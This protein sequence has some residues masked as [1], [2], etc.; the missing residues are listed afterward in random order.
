MILSAEKEEAKNIFLNSLRRFEPGTIN[1]LKAPAERKFQQNFI[2]SLQ[3]LVSHDYKNLLLRFEKEEIFNIL[4]KQYRFADVDQ[5]LGH[6]PLDLFKQFVAT[7]LPYHDNAMNTSELAEVY[8]RFAKCEQHQEFVSKYAVIKGIESQAKKME[9]FSLRA[10]IQL[11]L[12][13]SPTTVKE[14]LEILYDFADMCD[15]SEDGIDINSAQ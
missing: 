8:D 2:G 1:I 6:L 7:C 11:T 15:P 14:K 9:S 13:F 10:F 12:F 4:Q 3:T 5:K